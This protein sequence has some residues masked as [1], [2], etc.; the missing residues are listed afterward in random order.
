MVFEEK[1]VQTETI[2][3]SGRTDQA[4]PRSLLSWMYLVTC[5]VDSFS[6]T[7]LLIK[8]HIVSE[9]LHFIDG[10]YKHASVSFMYSRN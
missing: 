9:Q 5:K 1:S 10:E 4:I 7:V 8:C 3:Q 2:L 6:E